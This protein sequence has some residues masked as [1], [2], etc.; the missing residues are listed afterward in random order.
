VTHELALSL[1]AGWLASWA[2]EERALAAAAVANLMPRAAIVSHRALIKRE[3][4]QLAPLL[5]Y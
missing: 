4:E 2:A 3:R 5:H 1:L